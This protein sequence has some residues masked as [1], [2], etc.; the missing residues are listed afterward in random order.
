M[1]STWS[2]KKEI[3]TNDASIAML[4][5]AKKTMEVVEVVMDGYNG[6]SIDGMCPC[7]LLIHC[8][9]IPSKKGE[10]GIHHPKYGAACCESIDIH[11]SMRCVLY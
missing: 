11:L 1:A 2:I 10:C 6:G 8:W 9:R 4:D 3:H 7:I 5:L